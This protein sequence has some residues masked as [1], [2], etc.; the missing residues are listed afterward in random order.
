MHYK[1]Y[2]GEVELDLDAGVLYGR[3]IGIRDTVTFQSESAAE[4]RREFEASVDDYLAFCAERGEEPNKPYSGHLPF[5][6]TPERH[7]QIALA[8]SACGMSMNGWMDETLADAAMRV[9]AHDQENV[10]V[11]L[12]LR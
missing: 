1:G 11:A 5:R 12:S 3:V 8:A 9:F 2:S 6:T 7:R 10:R 4:I